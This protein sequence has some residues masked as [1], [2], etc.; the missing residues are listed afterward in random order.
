MLLYDVFI[1]LKPHQPYAFFQNGVLENLSLTE[2]TPH[3]LA[4]AKRYK[5]AAFRRFFFDLPKNKTTHVQ[6]TYDAFLMQCEAALHAQD[7]VNIFLVLPDFFEK[8]SQMN[9]LLQLLA[10]DLKT[11]T[12]ALRIIPLLMHYVDNPEAFASLLGFLVTQG[13]TPEVILNAHV[14]Q[15]YFRYHLFELGK[16]HNAIMALHAFLRAEP[17]TA[18]LACALSQTRCPEGELSSYALDGSLSD[19]NTLHNP[20]RDLASCTTPMSEA[21]FQVLHRVFGVTFLRA[22][23]GDVEDHATFLAEALNADAQALSDLPDL[24]HYAQSN[25]A[26]KRALAEC[27]L[28]ETLDSM[29]N[30]EIGGVLML[31]PYSAYLRSRISEI[32]LNTYLDAIQKSTPSRFDLVASLYELLNVFKRQNSD[33]AQIVFTTII[34]EILSEATLLDDEELLKQLRKFR[35]GKIQLFEKFNQLEITFDAFIQNQMDTIDFDYITIEDVWREAQLKVNTLERI[36]AYSSVIPKDKHALHSLLGKTLFKQDLFDL[37]KFT[38]ALGIEVS[39]HPNQVTAYERLL[40]NML[41]ALDDDVLRTEMI[42]RLDLG[43][44]GARNWRDATYANMTLLEQATRQGNL[45]LIMW[46]APQNKAFKKSIESLVVTAAEHHHWHL[47]KYFRERYPLKQVVV[48]HL[49]H[50]A[51]QN[52]APDIISFLCEGQRHR[53]SLHAIEKAFTEAVLQGSFSCTHALLT[54]EPSP[55]DTILKK[56]FLQAIKTKQFILASHIV[57]NRPTPFLE[58][59]I[60][61]LFIDAARANKVGTLHF[62][63]HLSTQPITQKTLDA[64]L[65]AAVRARSELA[66]KALYCLP[67]I[68]PRAEA[69][70]QA[71]QRAQKKGHDEL[72]ALLS[73]P[74]RLMSKKEKVVSALEGIQPP[75][76]LTRSQSHHLFVHKKRTIPHHLS[77]LSFFSI[78]PEPFTTSPVS[79][80]KCA[81]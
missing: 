68:T 28:D 41:V 76:L 66:V 7:K 45:G 65:R 34:D 15:D 57:E 16:P 36:T 26:Q 60:N 13:I 69:H 23:L 72:V 58:D 47:V 29:L 11:S 56:G 59:A 27:L 80:M 46:I 71:L 32:D 14:I 8:R 79:P 39:F 75:A 42:N 74:D 81:S 2:I 40:I 21:Q 63:G 10:F 73:N 62:L 25:E 4:S 1:A 70:K 17:E 78:S 22:A 37:D 19:A 35:P 43:M 6:A 51:V 33:S 18:E 50:L 54:G 31:L 55:C 30:A 20:V 12:D 48:D 77:R 9:Q 24:L 52:E 64:A 67:N 53:P 49:L 44:D 61:Q 3:D 5:T 38:Q